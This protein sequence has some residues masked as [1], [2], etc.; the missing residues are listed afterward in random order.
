MPLFRASQPLVASRRTNV[1]RA[2]VVSAL[3]SVCVVAERRVRCCRGHGITTI[4][5]ASMHQRQCVHSDGVCDA[6]SAA[7]AGLQPGGFK[8]SLERFAAGAKHECASLAA[9]S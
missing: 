4:E 3:E 5:H 8:Q 1:D 2:V 6:R 9:E 7:P